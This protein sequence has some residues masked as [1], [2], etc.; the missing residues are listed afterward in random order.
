MCGKHEYQSQRAESNAQERRKKAR[1]FPRL[2]NER[3]RKYVTEKIRFGWSPELIAGRMSRELPSGNRKLIF[4]PQVL[5]RTI[6]EYL[7]IKQRIG[8]NIVPHT[9]PVFDAVSIA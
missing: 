6:T 5:A 1:K 2:K 8:G 7:L 9:Q 4:Q 3:I